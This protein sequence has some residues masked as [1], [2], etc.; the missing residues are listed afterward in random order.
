MNST[1]AKIIKIIAVIIWVL[2]FILGIVNGIA[3]SGY[4]YLRENSFNVWMMLLYW[5]M[6]FII[7]IFYFAFGELLENVAGLRYETRALLRDMK[8]NDNFRTMN[9]RM[10]RMTSLM[11]SMAPPA[12]SEPGGNI[13][14]TAPHTAAPITNGF[15]GS[16]PADAVYSKSQMQRPVYDQIVCPYCGA[17][18]SANRSLCLH[19]NAK[20][21]D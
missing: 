10:V 19:C 20:F 17:V 1:V 5:V 2:G 4:S 16:A 21:V 13:S 3:V 9:E 6:F 14:A 18:Q 8:I 15:A 11:E 7:G 12:A